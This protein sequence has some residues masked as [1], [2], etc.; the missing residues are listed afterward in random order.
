LLR[1][2]CK[3]LIHDC[4]IEFCEHLRWSLAIG[5]D[6]TGEAAAAVAESEYLDR[7]ILARVRA[8]HHVLNEHVAHYHFERNHQGIA[9]NLVF[10]LHDMEKDSGKPIECRER[11]GGLLKFY[12]QRAA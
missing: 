10:L 9:N 1:N 11:L 7:M 12:H 5:E 2:A 4:D 6:R 8:L 3:Y